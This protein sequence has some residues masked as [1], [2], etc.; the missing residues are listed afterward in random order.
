MSPQWSWFLQNEHPAIFFPA[1]PGFGWWTWDLDGLGKFVAPKKSPNKSQAVQT[2]ER[3]FRSE[4]P[5][6]WSVQRV[7]LTSRKRKRKHH[8]N[9]V[10]EKGGSVHSTVPPFLFLMGMQWYSNWRL[11]ECSDGVEKF[12]SYIIQFQHSHCRNWRIIILSFSKMF[13]LLFPSIPIWKDRLKDQNG[14][15]SLKVIHLIHGILPQHPEAKTANV[16]N[17]PG[18]TLENAGLGEEWSF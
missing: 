1:I 11:G 12:K 13:F 5:Q 18:L 8:R 10:R 9:A 2:R 7:Q 14:F 16:S 15:L 3:F 4:S 17:K 6:P